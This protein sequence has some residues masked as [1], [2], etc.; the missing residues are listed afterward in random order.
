MVESSASAGP[1]KI[2]I[3]LIGATGA[4]GKEIVRHAKKDPRIDELA[5][6]VRTKLEEWKEE[7]FQ[8]KLK[9]ITMEN[10]ENM[11]PLKEQ[12][13]GYDAFLCTLGSRVKHG[14]ETFKKVDYHYPIGFGKLGLECGAQY[15]GLLS[16]TG[17]KA[18]SWFLYMRTK[19]EVERDMSKLGYHNLTIFRPGL[20]DNR[21][22]EKRVIEKI[23]SAIPFVTKIDSTDMGLA[24]LDHAITNSQNKKEQP[25]A[26]AILTN[27]QIVIYAR[28]VK[29]KL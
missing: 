20:L 24:M 4:I 3:A 14:E 5:L 9:V 25:Q 12:L 29:S 17:A 28:E 11:A 10:F 26:P 1:R 13:M 22:G 6:V 21:D 19:G 18:S 7:D 15:Y 2:R 23:F 27:D 16:S 8:C